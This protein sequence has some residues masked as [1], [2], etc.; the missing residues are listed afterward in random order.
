MRELGFLCKKNCPQNVLFYLH[1]VL[2]LLI[3]KRRFLTVWIR[4]TFFL[5]SV[6]V[7]ASHALTLGDHVQELPEYRN[8][9]NT[10]II[11]GI[12]IITGITSTGPSSWHVTYIIPAPPLTNGVH[13]TAQALEEKAS[14][15][16][17]CTQTLAV[18]T[19]VHEHSP[20]LM[21]QVPR[22]VGVV[23]GAFSDS[24]SVRWET[25]PG[26]MFSIGA[27]KKYRFGPFCC[28]V[29]TEF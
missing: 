2:L 29:A 1:S 8:Y 27:Y 15:I 6:P 24:V 25:S 5:L 23:M 9:Q 7:S 16:L 17:M 14:M 10:G 26:Q 28:E 22:K 20:H 19:R 21:F 18:G 13:I 3:H 12:I 11:T 4:L